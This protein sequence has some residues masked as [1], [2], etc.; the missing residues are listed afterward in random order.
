M[1]KSNLSWTFLL[2]TWDQGKS[3]CFGLSSR[4]NARDLGKIS[5]FVRNDNVLPLRLCASPLFSESG[6]ALFRRDGGRRRGFSSERP[7]LPQCFNPLGRVFQ[8][9]P[10]EALRVLTQR[11][12]TS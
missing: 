10:P 4:V 5:L 7:L 8:H 1:L 12:L 2:I 11:R 6:A 3:H 9:L